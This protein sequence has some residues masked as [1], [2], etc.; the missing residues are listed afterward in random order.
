MEIKKHPNLLIISADVLSTVSSNGK[1]MESFLS[2]WDPDKI[3]QLY[4]KTDLPPQSE[5]CRKYFRITD[6]EVFQSL[7]RRRA[8]IGSEVA[9]AE[10]KERPAVCRERKWVS[11]L[12]QF[13]F[14]RLLREWAWNR[15]SWDNDTLNRWLREV[16][17]DVILLQGGDGIFAYDIAA[18]IA[19][20]FDIPVVLYVTD[21]YISRKVGLSIFGHIRKRL[22]RQAFEAM[23]GQCAH[24]ITIG[25][26]MREEYDRL[27]DRDS[28]VLM[29]SVDIG[30]DISPHIPNGPLTIVY[31]GSL[32]FGR[33]NS[34]AALVKAIKRM[35][36]DGC[37][38]KLDIY[39][40]TPMT[41]RRRRLL[42]VDGCSRLRGF[43]GRDEVGER[44]SEADILVHIEGFN[45]RDV[46]KTRLSVSTKI[47]EYMAAGKC[48][49]AIGP[50][51]IASMEYARDFACVV[52]RPSQKELVA[53]LN[54]LID[55]EGLR[56]QYGDL[57]YRFAVTNHEASH[58]KQVFFD[59]IS[60]AVSGGAIIQA[61]G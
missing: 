14:V 38:I 29:N 59:I 39:T 61:I 43:I 55:D 40:S 50:K 30:N 3:A 21:D 17:P 52:N 42:D 57:A 31:M 25:E 18:V 4:V 2:G 32:Y 49:L 13:Y 53:V 26:K 27:F 23:A 15:A 12:K 28:V 7:F 10:A 36:R 34:L 19:A 9:R 1:T 56:Q 20:R 35:N 45:K 22:I 44:L 33:E 8:D 58:A 54:T 60:D 47:P 37:R 41:S 24:M 46:S 6:R 16:S 51:G 48:I 5:C 11:V